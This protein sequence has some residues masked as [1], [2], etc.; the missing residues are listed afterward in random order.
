MSGMGMQQD[1]RNRSLVGAFCFSLHPRKL[2][3]NNSPIDTHKQQVYSSFGLELARQHV[4][5]LHATLLAALSNLAERSCPLTLRRWLARLSTRE[6]H[7][8]RPR[9]PQPNGRA[10]RFSTR[11][12][13]IVTVAGTC[14]SNPATLLAGSAMGQGVMISGIIIMAWVTG[15]DS[16]K[17][18][19]LQCIALNIATQQLLPNAQLGVLSANLNR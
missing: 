14:G 4:V 16:A 10:R 7:A 8:R 12:L 11:S 6:L 3:S 9:Q 18:T 2:I 1:L 13:S 17:N 15:T 5:L 19:S